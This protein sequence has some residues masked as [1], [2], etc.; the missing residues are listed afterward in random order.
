MRFISS[1]K[2]EPGMKLARDIISPGNALMLKYGVT[3]TEE[4]IYYIRKLGYLGA[5]IDD[6]LSEGIDLQEAISH[7]TFTNGIK[8]VENCNVDGLIQSAKRIVEDISRLDSLKVDM[9]DLRSYD[10]YT[11][12]HSVNVAV[13][14]V[15]VGMYL[16]LDNNELIQL[17]QAGICH[18]LGKQKIPVAIINKPG[19]LTDEEFAEIKNHPKYSYN[20][21]ENDSRISAAVRQAVICHH[22]NENG[23]GYPFGKEGGEV[24]LLTRI[25]HV[26]D[27]YDALI[28][29][30][31]YKNPCTPAEAYEYLD[32]G[33][34]ILFNK[35]VVEAM[36]KVIPAYPLGT[37]INLSTGQRALVIEHSKDYLRPIVRLM[38]NGW[39]VD[40]SRKENAYIE[41][42]PEQAKSVGDTSKVSKLNEDR[43]TV[44]VHVPEIMLVDDSVVS[45]QQTVNILSDEDYHIIPLQSG[46]AAV[47][48]IK[49]NGAP[50][51]LIMDIEMPRMDG[52]KTVASIRNMG[53]TDLPVIFLTAKNNRE[54]VL[55]CREVNAKDYIIKPVIPAYLKT[56]VAVAL[57]ASLER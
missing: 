50:D 14:C 43:Q 32:G 57:D 2:L 3:L 35:T 38:E 54:T 22:E 44:K 20:I 16:E 51:L 39:P 36:K 45:L 23:S 17:S 49:K 27:V 5:Y 34:G 25:L 48:Y 18:D 6:F 24:S 4:Y 11:Y 7:T 15:A 47:N 10:D 1:D 33:V 41:I 29:R 26:V 8:A 31:P 53:H 46:L 52:V 42:V 12:H 56:R 40:L 21:I 9:Y 37:E 13:Y 55:R 28:S 30:R 19:K